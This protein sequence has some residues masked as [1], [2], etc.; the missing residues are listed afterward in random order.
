MLCSAAA[1][2]FGDSPKGVDA[3]EGQPDPE[4]ART[5]A[6]ATFGL[7]PAPASAGPVHELT[8]PRA[9]LSGASNRQS[10][11]QPAQS[12]EQTDSSAGS[13]SLLA[14]AAALIPVS[15]SAEAKPVDPREAADSGS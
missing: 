7:S 15:I 1:A 5:S 11:P 10:S 6:D 13:Q 4:P 9:R 12:G 14:A 3:L 2:L 8:Q